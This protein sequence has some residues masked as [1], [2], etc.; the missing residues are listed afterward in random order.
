[1]KKYSSL[2]DIQAELHAG[3]TT[4]PQVVQY[5]LERIEQ[6]KHLNAFLEVYA[7]E[8]LH[9][10][11]LVQDK[12]NQGTA[13]KLAGLVVGNKDVINHKGHFTTSASKI[14]GGYTSIYNATAIQRLLDED[15]IIIGR[16]NCDE[17][18]MGSSNENSAYGICKNGLDESKVPGG[19][20][21]GSA[22]AVQMDMCTVALGTDTGG[23]IRQPA[24]LCGVFGIKPTYGRVSRYGLIAYA[25]SFDQIGVFSHHIA[26]AAKVMEVISGKDL[27]DATSSSHP[28]EAYSQ[29]LSLTRK[30]KLASFPEAIHHEKLDT[31]ISQGMQ[32][33]LEKLSGEGHHT[34]MVSFAE[35][36]YLVP[37]YYLL[38]TAEASSNLARFD[39]IRFGYRSQNATDLD[40]TY[41][42]N[43]SEGFGTEVKRRIMLGT[44]V[45]SAGYYDAYYAKAQKMRR[46][47]RDKTLEILKTHDF[48][49]LPTTPS[50]A[51]GIGEKTKD[52]VEMYLADIYT[53]QA[54]ITGLPAVSVPLGKHSNGMPY[55]IQI[56]GNKFSEAELMAFAEYLMKHIE[57]K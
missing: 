4:L 11:A 37:T 26:D 6:H 10:A 32:S 33:L 31:E 56:I 25:S 53:V 41:R 23:S 29:S 9:R 39:G 18:A 54:N 22:V 50:T 12:I 28:V 35:L 40:S 34:D 16:C 38:T 47:I 55:G 19:S 44:F 45:L 2:S 42:K 1:M 30:L 7:D 15:A 52:P 24:S 13:G 27:M 48:I 21:G 46:L 17:F 5:Y 14:L 8:A 49:I 36:D 51:F 43:R 20:S 3:Q 57:L